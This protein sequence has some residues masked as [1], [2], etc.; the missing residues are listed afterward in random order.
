M[1]VFD[2]SWLGQCSLVLNA[3]WYYKIKPLFMKNSNIL[4]WINRLK[5]FPHGGSSSRKI[6]LNFNA[7]V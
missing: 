1:W 6:G 2:K 3:D 4:L 5:S 7:S